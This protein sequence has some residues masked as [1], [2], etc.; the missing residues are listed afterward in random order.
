MSYKTFLWL[1][2]LPVHL[3]YLSCRPESLLEPSLSRD[4]LLLNFKLKWSHKLIQTF[5]ST[6]N[7]TSLI[8]C[9]L[10]EIFYKI[11]SSYLNFEIQMT[12]NLTQILT[13]QLPRHM[14]FFCETFENLI[15]IW[16][17]YII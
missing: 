11:Q 1:K 16:S 2:S 7:K 17:R 3:N 13:V 15:Q 6:T 10:F 14:T 9:N 12:S 5:K 8:Y 4:E